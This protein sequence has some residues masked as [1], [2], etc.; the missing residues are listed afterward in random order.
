MFFASMGGDAGGL[1]EVG[2]GRFRVGAS[3]QPTKWHL[4]TNN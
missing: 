1:V 2:R 3:T 4:V